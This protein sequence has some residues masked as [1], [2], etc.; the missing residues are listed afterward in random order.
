MMEVWEFENTPGWGYCCQ[1]CRV[2]ATHG[3]SV[4]VEG[5]TWCK[6]KRVRIAKGSPWVISSVRVYPHECG[7]SLHS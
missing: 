7:G 1:V 3:V 5:R 6:P 4:G 2:K